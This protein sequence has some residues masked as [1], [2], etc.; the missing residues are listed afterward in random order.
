M[1]NNSENKKDNYIENNNANEQILI[2]TEE[3][4]AKPE[5]EKGILEIQDK[6]P[7]EEKENIMKYIIEDLEQDKI[8]Y[9]NFCEEEL[10]KSIK[11]KLKKTKKKV[12][13][14]EVDEN[15]EEMSDEKEYDNNSIS[16][17]EVKNKK[18]P[19]DGKIEKQ[20]L[21]EGKLFNEDRHQPSNYPETIN[22]RC[23][24]FRK[25]EGNLNTNFC[26]AIL[27]RKIGK[28]FYYYILEKNHTKSCQELVEIKKKLQTNLIGNYNDYL[29]KCYNYLDSSENY[30]KTE[31]KDVLQNIYN[32]NKY[33]FRLKENTIKNII[34]KW[35][36]NSLRFTK[37]NAI[38]HK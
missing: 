37:Y 23:T 35:K 6:M 36:S 2:I 20:V 18:F 34:G 7:K 11:E 3:N 5:I 1:K 31:F 15:L 10:N 32:E 19:L 30:K 28:N 14:V 22:Y 25:Q 29:I 24:K 27:K 16:I 8:F 17:Y 12:T 33:N 9:L 13:S 21:Y 26:N 4:K 38:E